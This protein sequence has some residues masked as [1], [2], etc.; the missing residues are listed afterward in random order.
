MS[1]N[2]P[3]MMRFSLKLLTNTIVSQSSATA[4]DHQC[5]DYIPGSALLGVAASRLYQALTSESAD[6]LFHSGKVRFSDAFPRTGGRQGWPLPLCWHQIKGQEATQ[7]GISGDR[8]IPEAVFDPSRV[9]PEEGVQPKQ[10]RDGYVTTCG[11]VI[12]VEK[13]YE[14]KTAI[15][16]QTGAAAQSQ[17]FG[18][19]SL[20]AGQEFGFTVT[21]DSDVDED[22][23]DQLHQALSGQAMVGRSRSAQFGQ[24]EI[25]P[26]QHLELPE[27]TAP[28]DETELRVWLLS[29]LALLDGNGNPTLEVDPR[30]LGLPEGSTWSASSSFLRTRSYTPFNGKRQCYD[31]Q[32][33]VISRG[34]VLIFRL[35]K[36][37]GQQSGASL[38]HIGQH[39]EM[40]LGQVLINPALLASHPPV[41]SESGTAP[42]ITE[43]P[44]PHRP[45]TP[46]TR[47]LSRDVEWENQGKQAEHYVEVII[48]AVQEALTSAA[49]WSGLPAGH[50]PDDAPNRA[51]WGKI[52]ELAQ[53]YTAQPDKLLQALFEGDH[54]LLRAK[55]GQAAWRLRTGPSTTLA[56]DIRQCLCTGEDKGGIPSALV[57]PALSIACTRLMRGAGLD[58]PESDREV[59]HEPQ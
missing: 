10:L 31:L 49:A 13:D 25:T 48:R 44:A 30:E 29:D 34:S 21:A 36:P 19:E 47:F 24:V 50:I 52:R 32:R 2:N 53:A 41:F 40:G 46:L 4:G 33:Q 28:D 6:A 20:R 15:N 5:L 37:I 45:D 26:S 7:T 23:L 35:P 59:S 8:L 11:D 9:E 57:P 27:T 17:L 38:M 58:K 56:D 54:A 39:Q 55:T 43:T 22:L 3:R 18:Y 12:K 42:E 51:Q 16:P 1:A 14:L